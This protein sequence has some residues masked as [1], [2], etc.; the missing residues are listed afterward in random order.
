VYGEITRHLSAGEKVRIIV[1]GAA[2]RKSAERVLAKV[3]VDLS[4]IEFLNFPT[5][6]GWMR[7]IGPMFV[8]A[9][10]G[11]RAINNFRFTGWAKYPNHRKDAR[12]HA[13]AAK[14]LRVTLLEPMINSRPF[15]LEGGAIDVNGSGTLMTTKEC[16]LDQQVQVR[17]P[18]ARQSEIESALSVSLGV[19][20]FIWLEK[21]IAGDDT[22]GHVDDLA[23]FVNRSTIVICSESNPSDV[24]YEPLHQNFEILET[25]RL[26]D[27][28]FPNVIRLP[29]P[30]PLFFEGLRLPAS[31]ANFYI[32]NAAVIVPTFNDPSDRIALGILGECFPDRKVVGIHAVDLVWGFG[33]LHCLSQQQPA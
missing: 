33:T 18:G 19:K 17:N 10:D 5:D 7:D 30:S 14:A 16:L 6:R 27:G 8:T 13:R 23:R 4:C 15:V 24:N 1:E 12:V 3:G 29:M 25:A 2:H 22:H 11:S 31:Y 32:G 28:S 9:N 21:G 20:N 26:E